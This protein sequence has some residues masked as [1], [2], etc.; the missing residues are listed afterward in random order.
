MEHVRRVQI[1]E[2]E[3]K[4]YYAVASAAKTACT[5]EGG[6]KLQIL[7]ALTQLRQVCCDPNLC[8]PTTRGRPANW[9]PAWS[10]VPV[11][12]RTATRFSCSP[13]LPLC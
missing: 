9:R 12:W 13:S 6:N 3:R 4:T 1:S 11:W 10:C 7:A 5:G 8:F 2:E